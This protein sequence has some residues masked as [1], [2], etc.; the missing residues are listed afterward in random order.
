MITG[1]LSSGLDEKEGRMP[2]AY[3]DVDRLILDR[4]EETQGFLEA[5]EELQDRMQEAFA[6]VGKRLERWASSKGYKSDTD[7]KAP[8]FSLYR[9][10]WENRRRD[11]AL[12][13]FGLE[14]C[15]PIGYRRTEGSHPSLWVHTRDLAG[16]KIK[17][18]DR[19]RFAEDLRSRLGKLA[20]EWH[21]D[22]ASDLEY[23]LGK[24]FVD[25]NGSDRARFASSP[26]EL[27]TFVTNAFEQAFPL[28]NAI[29]Q[30]L[31][32]LRTREN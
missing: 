10:T 19:I 22:D 27:F 7:S 13:Y 31:T 3:T 8:Y 23:P 18:S 6:D 26:E 17:E 5:Y 4:W 20:E 29:D 12:V 2:V 11:D 21:H 9:P 32:A 16:T 30:A 24:T 15:G 28:A 1:S 25:V 14:D